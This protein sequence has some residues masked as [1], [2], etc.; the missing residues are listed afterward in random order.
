MVR[1]GA[2]VWASA[3]PCVVLLWVVWCVKCLSVDVCIQFRTSTCTSPPPL[4][5]LNKYFIY[6]YNFYC[7]MLIFVVLM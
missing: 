4:F 6:I 2:A 3:G 5:F 7:V 1:R